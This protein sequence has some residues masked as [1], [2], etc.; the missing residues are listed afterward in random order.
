[1]CHATRVEFDILD[2]E[3]KACFV[4]DHWTLRERPV[5]MRHE[6]TAKLDA[7]GGSCELLTSLSQSG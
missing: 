1:M 4:P 7:A 5:L 6:N 2:S 3:S